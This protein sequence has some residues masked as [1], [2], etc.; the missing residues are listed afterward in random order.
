MKELLL[1]DQAGKSFTVREKILYFLMAGWFITLFLPD[2]PVLNNIVTGAVLLHSFFYN[3]LAEK[4]QYLRQRREIGFMLLF[5]VLHIVSTFFSLNKQEGVRM[6]V[7]RLPL[8]IF[9]LS[10]GL[11]FIRQEVKDRALLMFGLVTALMALACLANAYTRYRGSHDASNFYDDNLTLAIRRQSIYIALLVNLALFSLAYLLQRTSFTLEYPRV[12]WAGI[13]FLLVF[14]FM[15]ASRISIIILYSSLL[16]YAAWDI[17]SKRKYRQGAILLLGLLVCVMLLINVFPKTLNRFKELQYTGYSYT[18]HGIESHYNMT[19]TADQWNGANIRLA[20]WR[21][22]WDLAK[23]HWLAGVQL[24][25]KQD[26]L[27]DVYRARRF[28]FALLTVRNMHNTYLDVLSC[29]GIIGLLLFLG[30]WLIFP[31]WN[32]HRAGDGL[33]LVMALAFAVSMVTESYFDRSIGCL[34][35]GFFFCFISASHGEYRSS[36]KAARGRYTRHPAAS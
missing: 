3:T 11:L 32:C 35:A 36:V 21:C 18:G 23:R 22:G 19:V 14:H 7:L 26:R 4:W 29:F 24:G 25:D 15:L 13:L 8:L 17:V 33:G 1:L 30:G 10:L 5:Y 34:L 31:V 12:A 20:V 6:L 2:M 27:M 16:I 28:D 9:P